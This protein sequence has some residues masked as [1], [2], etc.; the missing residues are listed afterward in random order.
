METEKNGQKLLQE[1]RAVFHISE[2]RKPQKEI[3]EQIL[4]GRDV[5]AILPT[6]GGKSLCYQY[7]AIKFPGITIVISPLIAL[8][9]DQVRHLQE[10]GICAYC[11]NSE[12]KRRDRQ[13]IMTDAASGICKLLYVSPE[14]VT[15]P[16]FIRF[17]KKLDVSMVVVD[18]A[19]CISLWGYDFRPS[20]TK[21]PRF[22]RLL[23]KRPIIAAFTA[24]ASERIRDDISSL[25]E[26]VSPYCENA[27]YGRENLKLSV[28]HKEKN[29]EKMRTL[30]AY[31]SKHTEVNGIIYCST[32]LNVQDVYE[33]LQRKNYA[34]SQYYAALEKD[35][36]DKNY[37]DFMSGKNKIMVATNAFGMGID[38]EDI[39]YVIH[40]DIP[41]DIESYY[42]E[43]GRAGRDGKRSECIL[44]Y[45][46]ADVGAY[47]G[48]LEQ[49][50]KEAKSVQEQFICMLGKMRLHMMNDYGKYGRE[51]TSE[52]LQKKIADY[53]EQIYFL[54]E[55][56]ENTMLLEKLQMQARA[57]I[58]DQMDRIE[59]LYTNETKVAQMIRSGKY[60]A[61]EELQI[62]VGKNKVS[63]KYITAWM[64][65][66]LTYFDL[67]IA[68]AVYTLS[69]FGKTKFY[70]KNILELLAGDESATLK[71]EKQGGTV[72]DKRS[73]IEESLVRMAQTKIRIDQTSGQIGFYFSD[74]RDCKVIEGAFLPI[75]KE[76][77]NGF[78]LYETPPLY[79]Y[80][81]LTNGQFFTIP[82]KMLLVRKENGRKLPNSVENLK[83][84]HYMA[85]RVILADP[86]R[87]KRGGYVLSSYIRF[88]QEDKRRKGM[89]EILNFTADKDLYIQ[90]RKYDTIY[91]KIKVILEYYK[92]IGRIGAYRMIKNEDRRSTK[93]YT[94][95]E[96]DY[97]GT[98]ENERF[99][100]NNTDISFV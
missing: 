5:L 38:K 57:D 74:E 9:Q 55:K 92:R 15:S 31:L 45:S 94:A 41:K 33:R 89:F 18:E 67:M 72:S 39:R 21:I 84:K 43:S 91:E 87:A 37:D 51:L 25:L 85:R 20:Y 69:T 48:Y 56:D 100:K 59:V 70:I 40:Y 64:E 78:R 30:Y 66:K 49:K 19:H 4:S 27:G 8:M 35:E 13:K 47:Y 12:I 95:V 42:Q 97:Y 98:V 60:E 90:K 24:T 83:L 46:A 93:R 50:E 22:I 65:R 26:M 53:F 79:R 7:P 2:F 54:S 88:V 29:S 68:D 61:G 73:V 58:I 1:A 77:K 44:Y 82:H 28:K 32:V 62:N 75:R 6:G 34:V 23:E 14:R 76:G 80:A 10:K 81:E 36:K 52:S 3:I 86:M 96:L 17:V 11:L 71:P 16:A 63:S 99:C